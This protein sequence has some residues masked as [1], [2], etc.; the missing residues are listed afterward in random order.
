MTLSKV[1]V[2]A[3][4]VTVFLGVPAAY[5]QH[6]GGGGRSGGGPA[7]VGR[8][9]P[10]GIAPRVVTV[11]PVRFY[12]P[13]YVFRPRVNVGFGLWS[14]FPIAY[15]YGYYN[16]YYGS[17]YP[18]GAYAYPAPYPAYAYPYPA[19]AYPSYPQPGYPASPYPSGTYPSS[20]YPTPSSG[21]PAYPAPPGSIGVQGPN[22]QAMSGGLSFEITPDTAE[23]FVDGSYIGTVG[24]FTPSS[25][26]LG[27]SAGRH[28][29]EIRAPGYRT[30]DFDVEIVPGQVIPYQGVLER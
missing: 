9:A 6:R 21:A 13:Y 3:A 2:G 27:L 4:A 8:A 29:V 22:Q 11:A 7:V 16:P 23:V 30:M 15:S 12:R 18:Y 24:Q 10:R 17:Y 19:T 25:Q 20:P 5:A 28:R 26:P 1:L 14:G